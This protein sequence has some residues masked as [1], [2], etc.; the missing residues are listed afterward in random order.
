[1]EERLVKNDLVTIGLVTYNRS[2]LLRE[3]IDS[4]LAQTYTNFELIISD[5]CSSDDTQKICEQYA[6][7]DDR[8]RYIRHNKNIGGVNNFNFVLKRARGEY[9]MW[10]ADDDLWEPDFI[11]ELVSAHKRREDAVVAFC[12]HDIADFSG[13]VIRKNSL[14]FPEDKYLTSY[15]RF[16]LFLLS[17]TD[18]NSYMYGVFKKKYLGDRVII[19]SFKSVPHIYSSPDTLF[20]LEMLVRGPYIS[21]PRTLYHKRHKMEDVI[22]EKTLRDLSVFTD[23]KSLINKIVHFIKTPYYFFVHYITINSVIKKSFPYFYD[24]FR[25]YIFNAYIFVV[26]LLKIIPRTIKLLFHLIIGLLYGNRRLFYH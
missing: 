10:A 18:K 16:K 2:F 25:L 7:K 1:M 26:K 13:I 8:I 14:L 9:F 20:N 11:L 17:Q 5:D 15:Q 22:P 23:K 19:R 21:V 3:V 4:L 12:D 24:R 6:R